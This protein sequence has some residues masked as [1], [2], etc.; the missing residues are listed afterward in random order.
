MTDQ[1]D[2]LDSAY[3]QDVGRDDWLC[4][5]GRSDEAVVLLRAVLN[6]EHETAGPDHPRTLASR[7]DL[8][9]ALVRAGRRDE[10]IAV[11]EVLLADLEQILD[12]KHPA[13]VAIRTAV[14][15]LVSR[16]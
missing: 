3:H 10:A 8:A 7:E 4:R 13:T 15:G 5:A 14:E 12:P 16:D 6:Y 9:E 11:Y 2:Q 1:L